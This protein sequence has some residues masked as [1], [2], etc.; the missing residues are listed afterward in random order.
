MKI[1]HFLILISVIIFF[2]LIQ[3]LN[4]SFF[5]VKPNFVLAVFAA[6]L[7][8]IQEIW[9]SVFLLSVASLFLKFSPHPDKDILLF[10]GIG[11]LTI[12][13]AR[14]LPWQP[15][16]NCLVLIFVYTFIFYLLL[17]PS[18]IIS[19]V[20]IQEVLYNSFAGGAVF[21]LLSRLNWGEKKFGKI[22]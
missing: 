17:F 22:N 3:S 21:F 20:F 8:F 16:I 14:Y 9:E 19:R 1:R 2:S 15:L 11:V 18:M 6:A 10:F 7:F 5:G 4:I 13:V 12:I